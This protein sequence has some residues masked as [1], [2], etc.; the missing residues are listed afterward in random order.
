M[1]IESITL[2]KIFF[3]QLKPFLTHP[4]NYRVCKILEWV[5]TITISDHCV[6]NV[7]KATFIDIFGL[8]C[9]KLFN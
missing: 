6:M 8:Y 3:S 1:A 4:Y 2:Y 9:V 7:F 5:K